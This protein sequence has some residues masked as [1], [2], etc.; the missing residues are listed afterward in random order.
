[1]SLINTFFVCICDLLQNEPIRNIDEGQFGN[2][3]IF[4]KKIHAHSSPN[5]KIPYPR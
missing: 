1:M 2:L 3:C 4:E 5:L